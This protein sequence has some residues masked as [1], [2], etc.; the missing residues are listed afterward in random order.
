M[1]HAYFVKAG[2]DAEASVWISESNIP[3]LVIEAETLT[4]FEE[5]MNSLAPEMLAENV[6]IHNERV[7]SDRPKAFP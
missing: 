5:L 6:G 7:P 3:G 4:E 1:A 2:W